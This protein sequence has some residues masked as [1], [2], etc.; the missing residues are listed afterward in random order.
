MRLANLMQLSQNASVDLYCEEVVAEARLVVVRLLGGRSYWPYG[1]EQIVE[2][3]AGTGATLVLRPGAG[4]AASV[5]G[6]LV[7]PRCRCVRRWFPL[8]PE[9]VDCTGFRSE[10]G[11]RGSLDPYRPIRT[12]MV[13]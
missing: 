12:A 2:T 5:E 7:P 9:P 6:D 10:E 3:C 13:R 11:G 1:A 4:A 8:Y